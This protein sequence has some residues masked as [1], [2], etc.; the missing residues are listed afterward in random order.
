[1]RSSRK[2]SVAREVAAP[3][4]RAGLANACAVLVF[5]SLVP[6]GMGQKH[7]PF[8]Q[9]AVVAQH[10]IAKKATEKARSRAGT[11]PELVDITASTGIQFEHLSSSAAIPYL[12]EATASDP[13]NLPFRMVLA[14]SCLASKQFQC[15]LDVY[16]EILTLNAESAEADMLA[17][18]ALD[19]MNDHVGATQQF[20][21]AVKA[22][23]KEPNVHFG[24][25]YLLWA[26]GQYQEAAQ[27]FQSELANVP[28]HVEAMAYLADANVKMNHPEVALPLI[29]KTIRI[30][31]G[32]ELAHLD[33]GILYAN[34]GRRD[35][36]L[37]EL[38]VA[39]KLTND[40]NVHWRLA[41]LYQAMGRK[42]EANAEFHKTSSMTK[43]ADDSVSRKLDN[44]RAKRKATE[45]AAGASA[46][47]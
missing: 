25:G 42:D 22:N 47:Q 23:P 18:E 30:D 24:L 19:E 9:Q 29:E 28:T 39:A 36:A 45:G 4:F 31:P 1:M 32:M 15:V 7:S 27:E 3:N 37:R 21:A 13:P 41:R 14:H 38:K 2:R 35:N 33:L 17:G 20:R 26:Q 46:D 34:A 6:A 40:V 5:L 8:A 11:Y 12:K 43:A 44:A 16:H 10:G